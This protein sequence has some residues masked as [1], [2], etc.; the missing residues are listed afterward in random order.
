MCCGGATDVADDLGIG[1]GLVLTWH[2]HGLGLTDLG[3]AASS[4]TTA[5]GYGILLESGSSLLQEQGDHLLLEYN[6]A[7]LLEDGFTLLTEA[8]DRM[9]IG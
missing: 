2:R 7:L 4:T 8:G 6:F 5:T 3:V 1:R 9:V